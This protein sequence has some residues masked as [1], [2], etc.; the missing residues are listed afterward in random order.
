MFEGWASDLLASYLGQFLEVQREQLR[1]SL[2]SGESALIVKTQQP[3]SFA[4][5]TCYL[6]CLIVSNKTSTFVSAWR[7]GLTLEN[8]ALRTDAFDHLQLPLK[9]QHGRVGRVTA[10]VPWRAL[11]S[12]V[13]LELFDLEVCFRLL[14][15]ADLAPAA[16]A[17]RA[18]AA[19]QA[20]VAS[21]ELQALAGSLG[22]EGPKQGG[23]LLSLLQHALAMLLRRLQLTVVNVRIRIEDPVSGRSFGLVLGQLRTC[24]PGEEACTSL[25]LSSSTVVGEPSFAAAKGSI[26]KQFSAEGIQ[27]YWVPRGADPNEDAAE[28]DWDLLKPTTVVMELSTAVATA[29]RR[30]AQVHVAAV[31][32]SL[33]LQVRSSQVAD[34]MACV[35][36]VQWL[37]ARA[38]YAHLR[39]ATSLGAG[40]GMDWKAM[41]R[42]AVDA[43]LQD[44]RGP[45][46]AARWQALDATQHSRRRYVLLYRKK[47]ELEREA[48]AAPRSRRTGST[49]AEPPVPEPLQGVSNGGGPLGSPVASPSRPSSANSNNLSPIGEQQL[50]ELEQELSVAD[51]V[52]CRTAAR[53]ALEGA[54]GSRP[55]SSGGDQS[56]VARRGISWGIAKAASLVGFVPAALPGGTPLPSESEVQEL[57]EAVDFNPEEATG[58]AQNEAAAEVAE[59]PPSGLHITMGCLI[60]TLS[61]NLLDSSGVKQA[62][63]ELER[64]EVEVDAG[65]DGTVLGVTLSNVVAQDW[66]SH[67]PGVV[68]RLLERC[69]AP[70]AGDG[71][72]LPPQLPLVRMQLAASKST[73]DLLVQP[74]RLHAGVPC[75]RALGAFVPVPG[76]DSFGATCMR[77]TNALST[78]ARAALKAQHIR[79]LGRCIDLVFKLVDLEVVIPSA[80]SRPEQQLRSGTQ[81]A[82]LR[83]GAL[84]VHSV[85]QAE[86]TADASRVFGVLD[87]LLEVSRGN[88]HSTT[89]REELTAAAAAVEERLVYQH[90]EFSAAGIE[91]FCPPDPSGSQPEH[92]VL[93]PM[94][95]SGSLKLHRIT[96]DYGL[97]QVVCALHVG[98]MVLALT[99]TFIQR[100]SQALATATPAPAN[101]LPSPTHA[102]PH[103]HTSP[104]DLGPKQ[105]VLD[106]HLARADVTY[107]ADLAAAGTIE[108]EHGADG[109]LPPSLTHP[110]LHYRLSLR[111]SSVA[112]TAYA[113]GVAARVNLGGLSVRDV[114][115]E[116]GFSLVPGVTGEVPRLASRLCV[117]AA[118][119]TV[120]PAERAGEESSVEV[121]LMDL[122]AV[123][124]EGEPGN[125]I[126]R[127]G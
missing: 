91:F 10:Q 98:P 62:A 69:A 105:A 100:M 48:A 55:Q 119:I 6:Y 75:L 43:V 23:M 25:L 29:A 42:Y 114:G 35:D 36:E 57:Y 56:A 115:A 13:V 84:I 123:G 21:E 9:L 50:L 111:S 33:P 113:G 72:P 38:K 125:F 20:L 32:H 99:P 44:F 121:Q 89:A 34:I 81:V 12:P 60:T 2:W 61:I 41:W 28:G 106:L 97:P 54:L 78:E 96:E 116:A 102:A 16:A 86:I 82:T 58:T 14:S 24:A 122:S 108:S 101:G 63:V 19:K 120:S 95:L 47:L 110:S 59:V 27:A 103:P 109:G 18:A 52:T 85:G 37:T 49:E 127:W 76:L 88:G 80:N 83:T 79:Q 30:T 66:V 107:S 124:F 117:E 73:L 68:G 40:E 112:L 87:R 5:V 15:P 64:L 45:Q 71:P 1:V 8:V 39:Q 31:V 51:I 3:H 7:T 70:D 92:A 126:S 77:A 67:G 94:K 4:R 104:Q 90:L 53:Q 65:G 93:H 74:L 17:A 11:S 118:H 22:P 46:R 26:Q